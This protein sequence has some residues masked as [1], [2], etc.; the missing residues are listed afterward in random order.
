MKAKLLFSRILAFLTALFIVSFLEWAFGLGRF[1]VFFLA[2]SLIWVLPYWL[3]RRLYDGKQEPRW[4][5]ACNLVLMVV[6]LGGQAWYIINSP[7]TMSPGHIQNA[8]FIFLTVPT[9]LNL[10][11]VVVVTGVGAVAVVADWKPRSI[12]IKA[13]VVLIL[14]VLG[15]AAWLG[16][17]SQH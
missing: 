12:L 15:I 9:V 4:L 1:L 13:S 10:V 2:T 17:V 3:R 6:W 5:G 14:W 8:K 16:A 7:D 11:G